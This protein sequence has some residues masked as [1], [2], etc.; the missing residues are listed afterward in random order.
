M[1]LLMSSDYVIRANRIGKCFQ[2]Y[3]HP[4]HRLLQALYRQ[5]KKLYEEFWALKDITVDVVRGETLGI[6][7]KNG[8]GKS[9]FLQ[10]VAGTLTPS[11]G[12]VQVEG[13]TSA[14]LELGAGFNPDF[15]GRENARL[16]ASI[17]GMNKDEIDNRLPHIIEFSE[18]GDFID[19][20]V[21][22]YSSGMYI[23]LAFSTSIS[24][25]PEILII[26]EA[27]AVGDVKF[28]R[29]CFRKLEQMRNDGVTILFV[30][31]ATDSVVGLCDR[32]MF[33]DGGEVKVL[34]DPKHVV[35]QYLE[36]MFFSGAGKKHVSLHTTGAAKLRSTEL[37]LQRG[38]DSCRNRATYND[39]EYR[40]GNKDA[41]IVDYVLLGEDGDEI[42]AGC[43]QGEPIVLQIGVFFEHPARNII[44]GFTI[45]TIDGA[46]VFGTNSEL[47]RVPV[48]DKNQEEYAIVDFE[49]S[50]HLVPGEYF[51]SLGVVKQEGSAPEIVLDRRYDLIHFRINEEQ[52]DAYGLAAVDMVITEKLTQQNLQTTC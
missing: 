3:D 8:S 1:P 44:Y 49:F 33:L 51:I 48:A 2:T 14:I 52:R 5:K 31:H 9:T 16:N 34:G 39:S 46:T 41:Q 35:N 37:A 30:T 42:S 40:W 43:R 12:N 15:T 38:H 45:K 4:V 17:L 24:L 32:A 25:E 18:L 7:G 13:R 29:K 23:R 10:I 6:V 47:K 20:P 26:D 28:Q 19:R 27:L 22:T 50:A 21:K 11:R 36:S